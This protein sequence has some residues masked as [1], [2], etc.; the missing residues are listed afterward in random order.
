MHHHSVSTPGEPPQEPVAFTKPETPDGAPAGPPFPPPFQPFPPAQPQQQPQYV[1]Y[2]AVP[3]QRRGMGVGRIVVIVLAVLLSLFGVA[4]AAGGGA[5]AWAHDSRDANGF[6]TTGV[7][8]LS[9]PTAVLSSDGVNIDIEG[10]GWFAKHLGTLHIE[11]TSTDGKPLFIGVGP[12]ADVR[13]WLGPAAADRVSNLHFEPFS[14]DYARQA[15]SLAAVSAPGA[16]K[17]W[18]TRSTG[19]TTQTLNWKITRGSWAI[20]VANADGSP[21]VDIHARLGAKFSWLGPLSLTLIIIGVVLF[22]IGIVIIVVAV[23]GRRKLVQ[24][25][26]GQPGQPG[27]PG[28]A[29]LQQ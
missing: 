4:V 29:P 13:A 21:G 17:F 28:Q 22:L 26:T 2:G 8:R 25:W 20:V 16:Q 11:A 5:L 15:G 23:R 10:T 18:T 3:G 6:L 24:P 1:P 27:Q 7:E 9:T 12:L 19:T 14:V